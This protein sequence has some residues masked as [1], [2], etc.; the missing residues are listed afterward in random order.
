[1]R[2]HSSNIWECRFARSNCPKLL[3]KRIPDVPFILHAV[4]PPIPLLLE[5]L[6]FDQGREFH[7]RYFKGEFGFWEIGTVILAFAA[8]AFGTIAVFGVPK[9]PGKFVRILLGILAFGCFYLAGEEASWGQHIFGW[10]S[11]GVWA[12]VNY[13][14][15]TNLH[16]IRVLSVTNQLP[17]FIVTAAAI[18]GFFVVPW[19]RK[20]NGALAMPWKSPVYWLMPTGVCAVAALLVLLPP[21]PRMLG[22]GG[23]PEPGETAEFYIAA[24]LAVYFASIWTRKRTLSREGTPAPDVVSSS[25]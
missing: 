20:K 15:E 19:W 25:V 3:K 22:I 13:Q 6:A 24:L 5:A 1:M 16:N 17:R 2:A 12:D 4:L 23:L 10:Q 8:F 7:A 14:A 18:A 9:L 11:V 21:V